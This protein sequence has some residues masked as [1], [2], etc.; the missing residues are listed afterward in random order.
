MH[1]SFHPEHPIKDLHIDIRQLTVGR[2]LFCF[3]I[4]LYR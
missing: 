1:H 3:D 4:S 2:V